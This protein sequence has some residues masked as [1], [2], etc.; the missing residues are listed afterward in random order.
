MLLQLAH[1]FLPTPPPQLFRRARPIDELPRRG[2]EV[3]V[4]CPCRLG[5]GS[6]EGA[7]ECPEP[8][9][10]TSACR[11]PLMMRRRRRPPL[12]KARICRR[13]RRVAATAL[14]ALDP[15][16]ARL[17]IRSSNSGGVPEGRRLHGADSDREQE[18]GAREESDTVGIPH[19]GSSFYRFRQ[20]RSGDGVAV[21]KPAD[22]LNV[23]PPLS[24]V[25]LLEPARQHP[26]SVRIPGRPTRPD[27]PSA[28]AWADFPINTAKQNSGQ[29]P[30]RPCECLGA[31]RPTVHVAARSGANPAVGLLERVD[32]ALT[33]PGDSGQ[34]ATHSGRVAGNRPAGVDTL[35]P[36]R[37]GIGI[38]IREYH[39]PSPAWQYE[40]TI[41]N[42]LGSKR[43]QHA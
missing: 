17:G 26:E 25:C 4:L 19:A 16:V 32:T 27:A 13:E 28:R 40:V 9:P 42:A 15:V 37:G 3:E 34:L 24:L 31:G 30:G 29:V 7:L 11:G 12:P 18:G 35:C 2:H 33:R 36:E 38:A 22:C 6:L 43:T 21:R 5:F 41:M 8:V 39:R 10:V 20:L 23:A 1:V 14:E